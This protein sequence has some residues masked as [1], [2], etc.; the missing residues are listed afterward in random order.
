MG[1]LASPHTACV[2]V[3][4]RVGQAAGQS[5]AGADHPEEAIA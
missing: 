5:E 1:R 3:R 2:V 4:R